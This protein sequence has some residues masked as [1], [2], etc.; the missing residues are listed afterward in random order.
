MNHV[1]NYKGYRFFQSSFDPDRMG[2]VL[3]VNHDYWGTLISYIGYGLLFLG[4]FVIFFW[5]GT[6]FWKLNKMLKDVNK[7]KAAIV[8]LLF[9]SL[10]INAQKI[11]TH[12]TTD[13]SREHVHVEGDG[14]TH[15]APAPETKTAQDSEI[16]QNSLAS[17]MGKMRTISAD[18]IIARNKISKE[19]AEKFGYLLVQNFEGRIIP[20]NTQALEV[21]RKLYKHDTFKGTDGK[22]LDANQWFLSIN[23]DTES[24]TSVPLIKVDEKGGKALLEKNKSQ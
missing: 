13:G 18:E 3:S 17:P 5:K 1:L 6:H 16:K 2:T 24:W 9:L 15:A 19:H 10:G 11:E 7:K 23:T 14:H 8:L 20:M 4:M 12:G 21:L 22:S